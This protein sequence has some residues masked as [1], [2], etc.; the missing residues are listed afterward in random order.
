[1]HNFKLWGGEVLE[2]ESSKI[3]GSTQ[4]ILGQNTRSFRTAQKIPGHLRR[5]CS[6]FFLW[7][8]ITRIRIL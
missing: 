5:G 7:K 8:T 6:V 3:P 1:M 2:H 4:K